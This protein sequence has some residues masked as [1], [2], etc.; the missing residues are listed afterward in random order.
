MRPP[1]RDLLPQPLLLL[2]VEVLQ[3]LEGGRVLCHEGALLE[4]GQG[5]LGQALFIDEAGD[6]LEELVARDALEGVLDLTLQVLGEDCEGLSALLLF[7]GLGAFLGWG[8]RAVMSVSLPCY[9][10]VCWGG[11]GGN[12]PWGGY[13]SG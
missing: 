8:V 5:V 2:V 4:Q 12:G 10:T 13:V 11:G 7:G 1:V 3:V 9:S 6:V